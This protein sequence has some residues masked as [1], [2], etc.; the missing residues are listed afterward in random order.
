MTTVWL[1]LLFGKKLWIL[2]PPDIDQSLL[3]LDEELSAYDWITQHFQDLK[4]KMTVCM[5]RPGETIYVPTG[6][7][8]VGLFIFL[9]F[10]AEKLQVLN[11]ETSVA[12]S[13]NVLNA[14]NY[15]KVLS[16]LD[17]EVVNALEKINL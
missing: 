11:V 10:F 1:T 15:D 14:R 7:L 8:H 12:L 5:Q 3:F 6:W 13:E 4:S 2:F 17:E 16:S 9:Y